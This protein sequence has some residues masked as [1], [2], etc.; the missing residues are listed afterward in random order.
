MSPRP[1]IPID[2]TTLTPESVERVSRNRVRVSLTAAAL[3]RI[4]AAARSVERLARGDGSTYGINTGLGA[5]VTR[6]VDPAQAAELS[7]NLVLSHASGVGPPFE[8]EI[9][10][11]AILIRLNTIA[12]GLSGVRPAV[13]ETL[14]ALLNRGV[15]PLVPSQGSLGASGD[16]APLA[17]L[18][19]A[20]TRGPDGMSPHAAAWYEGEL[21]PAEEALRR[22]EISPV[23]LGPKEGLSLTNGPAFSAAMLA[24]AW[25]D[26]GRL[27]RAAEVAGA[28]ARH[29][30]GAAPAALDARLHQARGHPGQIAVARRLRLLTRGGKVGGR[31]PALQDPY[32]LRCIPQILGAVHEAHG[33]VGSVLERELNGATDNPLLFE[34]EAVSGGN[35]HGAPLAI[36]ADILKIAMSQVG[37]L[38]ERQI[39]RLVD[40]PPGSGLSSMLV[41]D[42]AHAGLHSGMMMLQYTAA[43]LC[44]ENQ[45]LAGPD[46]TRSL[47]TSAGQEDL[48]PNA[49][50]AA[51]NLRSLVA[52]IRSILAIELLAAG[53]ALDLRFLASPGDR[54]PRAIQRAHEAVRSRVPFLP[55]DEPLAQH[56]QALN[57]MLQDPTSLED[58]LSSHVR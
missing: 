22:A 51:R 18:A 46:S 58:G 44:L 30:L 12:Q 26:A 47:P 34:G 17:H 55:R 28:M 3:R 8:P 24:L 1:T 43:S 41:A 39:D 21:L 7:R 20:F 52:N 23:E 54:P 27:L 6:R 2:G 53:Q 16:L 32:S 13:A 9:V 10:R 37:A 48:N 4:A 15:T 11:A 19:L 50:T 42:E 31:G 38:A 35:F 45:A 40:P 14:V 29:A 49:A 36:A 57:E 56:I 33:Y 25:V 5:F